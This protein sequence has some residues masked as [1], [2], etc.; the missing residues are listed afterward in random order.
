MHIYIV[1]AT[2]TWVRGKSILKVY[3]SIYY[4]TREFSS[5]SRKR[6][7]RPLGRPKRQRLDDE[8]II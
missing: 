6:K 1:A 3:S 7:Y 8:T 5:W 4:V 2:K